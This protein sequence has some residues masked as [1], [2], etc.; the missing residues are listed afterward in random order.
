MREGGGGGQGG[1]GWQSRPMSIRDAVRQRRNNQRQRFKL[2]HKPSK[3][4]MQAP[5]YQILVFTFNA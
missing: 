3:Q 5:S 1:R 2:E 4:W